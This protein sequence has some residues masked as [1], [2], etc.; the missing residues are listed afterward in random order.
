MVLEIAYLEIEIFKNETNRFL[1]TC[2]WLLNSYLM[3]I[4]KLLWLMHLM[5]NICHISHNAFSN[6]NSE[7]LKFL[8]FGK[9]HSA[10]KHEL[11]F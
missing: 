3:G 7:K 4:I 1:G 2:A 5:K 9:Y 8:L 11:R 6:L 10:Y